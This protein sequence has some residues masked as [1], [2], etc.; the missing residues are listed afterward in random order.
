MFCQLLKEGIWIELES[1]CPGSVMAQAWEL[2]Y[3]SLRSR[4]S[5]EY[6]LN[7]SAMHPRKPIEIRN[8]SGSSQLAVLVLVVRIRQKMLLLITMIL[9]KHQAELQEEP[10]EWSPTT[11]SAAEATS[12]LQALVAIIMVWVEQT[13]SVGHPKLVKIWLKNLQ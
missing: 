8:N 9:L 6:L 3:N 2:D 11:A 10:S 7:Q 4:L 1:C 12:I 13:I 5:R